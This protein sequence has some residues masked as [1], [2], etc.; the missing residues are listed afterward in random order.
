MNEYLLVL[1]RRLLNVRFIS[2]ESSLKVDAIHRIT[3]VLCS[4]C[5]LD[6]EAV[7]HVCDMMR[8]FIIDWDRT[9]RSSAFRCLRYCLIREPSLGQAFVETSV[10]VLAIS[11]LEACK[12]SVERAAVLRFLTIWLSTSAGDNFKTRVVSSLVELLVASGTVGTNPGGLSGF[13]KTLLN[14]ILDVADRSPVAIKGQLGL[15]LEF[16][17]SF[18]D[19]DFRARILSVVLRMVWEGHITRIPEQMISPDVFISLSRSFTGA[20]LLARSVDGSFL[21]SDSLYQALMDEEVTNPSVSTLIEHFKEELV[22]RFIITKKF[23]L[24][25]FFKSVDVSSIQWKF[26]DWLKERVESSTSGSTSRRPLSR[27]SS[28]SAAPVVDLMGPSA[29]ITRANR[30]F[31]DAQHLLQSGSSFQLKREKLIA[32]AE[33]L[34]A[35]PHSVVL[36]EIIIMEICKLIVCSPRDQRTDL[37][38]IAH[39][40]GLDSPVLWLLAFLEEPEQ[41]SIAMGSGWLNSQW[42]KVWNGELLENLASLSMECDIDLNRHGP[43]VGQPPV[44]IVNGIS[45]RAFA[46]RR[47]GADSKSIQKQM[48]D[49]SFIS[50]LSCPH[51]IVVM[52]EPLIPMDGKFT[53]T[54]NNGKSTELDVA[55]PSIVTMIA[56]KR[57]KLYA[58]NVSEVTLGPFTFTLEYTEREEYCLL[59]VAQRCAEQDCVNVEKLPWELICPTS[60]LGTTREGCEWLR[61]NKKKDLE[62][63]L[64]NVES[65]ITGST[66]QDLWLVGGLLMSGSEQADTL[67][68]ELGVDVFIRRVLTGELPSAPAIVFTAARIAEISNQR[69]GLD[70]FPSPSLTALTFKRS[71]PSIPDVPELPPMKRSS[72]IAE[73]FTEA[74]IEI[75][76]EIDTLA[77]SVHFKQKSASL[78]A[79]KQ[80]QGALFLSVPLWFAVMERTQ[81][82][83]FPLQARRVVHSLFIH[84]LCEEASFTILDNLRSQSRQ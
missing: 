17:Q 71:V 10:D 61:A 21:T 4:P 74:H 50:N 29:V 62:A 39:L 24:L 69:R 15:L 83:R 57:F 34:Y 38:R 28:V 13:S 26:P 33:D 1:G 51:W 5:D 41:V 73:A 47:P 14:M 52:D 48:R 25:Q 63:A 77:S 27:R 59:A 54:A 37:A 31:T 20:A 7:K 53:V 82:G 22:E 11:R 72:V 60:V 56:E 67:A 19:G 46:A 75:L 55:D 64:V 43:P 58:A 18:T 45:Y 36:V 80:K 3:T 42:N 84:T 49:I 8:I 78:M 30:T 65:C 44:W 79:K 23:H 35:N 9:V 16:A 2:G 76:K 12:S 6:T 81:V 70:V 66:T 68:N 32:I 40:P